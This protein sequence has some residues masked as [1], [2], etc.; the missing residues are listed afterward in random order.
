MRITL[1]RPFQVLE[2]VLG[3]HLPVYLRY[4]AGPSATVGYTAFKQMS[5]RSD[6]LRTDVNTLTSETSLPRL[7]V[8]E[9]KA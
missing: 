5:S 8:R 3:A 2:V 1:P 7:S 6:Q 4:S 9:I